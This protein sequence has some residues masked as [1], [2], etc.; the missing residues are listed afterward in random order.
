M[1]K[2]YI[3]YATGCL[4]NILTVVFAIVFCMSFSAVA[5][6]E[7]EQEQEQEQKQEREQAST[8][9]AL[10]IELEGDYGAP[11]GNALLLRFVPLWRLPVKE[12]WS[13]VNIDLITLADAPPLPG[14]P[15]NPDPIPGRKE[16]GLSDLVHLSLYTPKPSGKFIWG[17]GG[18]VSLPTAT[19]DSLGS[20]KWA[21][22]P[23]ARIVYKGEIWTM[24]AILG[25]RWSF[26][27]DSDR[28]DISS[29]MI[30]GSI[31]R[32]LGSD[33]FF[34]SAP[35]IN[36]NWNAE[37]GNRWLVP[38]GG[39]VGKTFRMGTQTWAASVQAY[40]NLIKPKGAPDWSLRMAFVA[41]IPRNW[42]QPGN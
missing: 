5:A 33:W 38:V 17:V 21:A 6:Q 1:F 28:A 42:Y 11:N 3:S 29:L 12:N 26:A 27:G 37:S 30:R 8:H 23:A 18:I 31:H 24:G 40:A 2:S 14:S 10:P 19:E 20:G 32:S 36:A 16:A 7:Q 39:G 22:G 35:I 25:Q 41:H 9:F 15:I 34:V 4:R 13:L